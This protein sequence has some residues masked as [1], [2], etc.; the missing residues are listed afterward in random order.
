MLLSPAGS[1]MLSRRSEAPVVADKD[2]CLVDREVAE[3]PMCMFD[4]AGGP[5]GRFAWAGPSLIGTSRR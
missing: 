5:R 3:S 2:G 1:S 4:P